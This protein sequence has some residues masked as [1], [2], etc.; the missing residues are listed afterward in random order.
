MAS[1]PTVAFLAAPLALAVSMAASVAAEVPQP[2]A[3]Q[4]ARG[5][6][7]TA[8]A[9]EMTEATSGSAASPGLAPAGTRTSTAGNPCCPATS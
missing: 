2:V 9:M 7:L 6:P 4:A 1:V 3:P 5:V 8:L